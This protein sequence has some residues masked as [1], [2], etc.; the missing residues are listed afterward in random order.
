MAEKPSPSPEPSA[1]AP[2]HLVVTEATDGY[3]RGAIVPNAPEIARSLAGK[4]RPAT[5]HDLGVAGIMIR[6]A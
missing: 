1:P 2:T 5:P 6:K 4:S 3:P